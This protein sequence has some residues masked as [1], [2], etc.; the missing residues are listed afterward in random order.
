[1][2][3]RIDK[4]GVPGPDSGRETFILLVAGLVAILALIVTVGWIVVYHLQ[5]G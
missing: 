5:S 1:M 3:D 4:T 2:S